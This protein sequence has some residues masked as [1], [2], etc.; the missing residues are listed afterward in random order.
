MMRRS[1]G[2]LLLLAL[3]G[4]C[5]GETSSIKASRGTPGETDRDAG[6]EKTTNDAG[7]GETT[8]DA[9]LRETASA[10]P[11]CRWPSEFDYEAGFPECWPGRTFLKCG[12]LFCLGDDSEHCHSSDVPSYSN[13]SN[14]CAAN[15][16]ALFGYCGNSPALHKPPAGCRGIFGVPSGGSVYCCPCSE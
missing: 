16:Y 15:E 10:L 11:Q 4:A 2:A 13:C 8:A 3:L 1:L 5:G 14:Q 7:R 12:N 6:A 9:V